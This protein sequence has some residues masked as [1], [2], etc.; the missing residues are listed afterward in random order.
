MIRHPACYY[1]C[2]KIGHITSKTFINA[3]SFLR[4]IVGFIFVGASN[5]HPCEDYLQYHHCPSSSVP[6]PDYPKRIAQQEAPKSDHAANL[7]L[8]A[9]EPGSDNRHDHRRPLKSI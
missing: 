8:R 2:P 5:I 9:D 3:G 4:W 1:A 7:S 6:A